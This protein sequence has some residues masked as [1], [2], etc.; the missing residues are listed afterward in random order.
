VTLPGRILGIDYGSRRV[1]LALS[2]PLGVIAQGAGTIQN[3][4]DLV[5]RIARLAGEHAVTGI[6]VGMPY[7]PNGEMGAKAVEVE[8]FIR[9]LRIA[10]SVPVDTWDES[11]TSVEA[12]RTFLAGG[13]K[14]KARQEKG[15]VDEMAARLLL[16]EYLDSRTSR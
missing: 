15:R 12:Q 13:M 7:G 16:Q 5:E 8:G 9:T 4:P 10:V 3:A 14:K 1:G 6:V 2:D 11:Y